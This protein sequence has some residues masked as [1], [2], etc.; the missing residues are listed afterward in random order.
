MSAE[1][2]HPCNVLFVTASTKA[3]W[4]RKRA[5]VPTAPS[6]IASALTL[7]SPSLLVLSTPI[8][9]VKMPNTF[10]GIAASAVSARFHCF[11]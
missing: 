1:G 4:L 2:T 3:A 7:L 5:C 9:T 8:H 6:L 11:H 10:D